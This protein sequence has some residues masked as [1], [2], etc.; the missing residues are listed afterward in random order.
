MNQLL[1]ALTFYLFAGITLSSALMVITAR[2]PVHSVFFLILSFFSSAGLFVLLGA[3]FLAMLLVVVYVGAVA[4]LF[5]FVVMML[6]IPVPTLKS[7]FIP[8]VKEFGQAGAIL[9]S[10]TVIFIASAY[11]MMVALS[12]V[13]L[14]GLGITGI[15]PT[16]LTTDP[17]L[18]IR[19]PFSKYEA[20]KWLE[21]VSASV[22]F[23]VAIVT[24]RLLAM[25]VLKKKFW[26]A[27][28]DFVYQSPV[29]LIITIMLFA[30]LAMVIMV[31]G[32]TEIAQ[33]MTLLPIPPTTVLPNTHAL[34]QVLY[35]DYMY[36]F[37]TAGLILLVAMIGAIVLTHRHRTDARRQSISSQ[38]NRTVD[39][40]VMVVKVNSGEGVAKWN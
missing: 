30:E 40:S 16:Q 21:F 25:I 3:E 36:I 9:L 18:A 10:Y 6:D 35:T 19:E 29:G 12:F 34:G 28:S 37:Q 15:D 7:W 11:L 32:D 27:S 20:H 38:N 8:K 17:L 13:S 23:L 14:W 31:W 33:E 26:K 4:V 2:N 5:L 22:T 39:E 1:Q 24:G